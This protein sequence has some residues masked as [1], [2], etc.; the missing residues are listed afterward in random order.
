MKKSRR[1]LGK[2]IQNIIVTISNRLFPLSFPIPPTFV[3]QARHNINHEQVQNNG[4]L[5]LPSV[6]MNLLFE[7]GPSG[8]DDFIFLEIAGLT[9][10][11]DGIILRISVFA[12]RK[13][14]T[15]HLKKPRNR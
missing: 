4:E 3:V 11:G 12:V 10:V 6:P 7:S 1:K 15:R 13:N 14:Q 8:F 2:G 5:I 9:V